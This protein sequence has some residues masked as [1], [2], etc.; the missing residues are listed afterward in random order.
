MSSSVPISARAAVSSGAKLSACSKSALAFSGMSRRRYQR[1]AATNTSASETSSGGKRS[2]GLATFASSADKW[3][4]SAAA[5]ELDGSLE[6]AAIAAA[7]A[8]VFSPRNRRARASLVN[9]FGSVGVCWTASGMMSVPSACRPR[10]SSAA[11]L[12]ARSLKRAFGL[13]A[14]KCCRSS[15]SRRDSAARAW[16]LRIRSRASSILAC[17]ATSAAF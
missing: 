11:P 9:A 12:L 5:L 14:E 6:S 4:S 17:S 15:A 7:L 16:P 13:A 2:N 3:I 8:W 10:V 1:A